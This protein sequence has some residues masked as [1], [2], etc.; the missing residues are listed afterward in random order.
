MEREYVWDRLILEALALAEQAGVSTELLVV[1]EPNPK[2]PADA[3]MELFSTAKMMDISPVSLASIIS[4]KVQSLPK[5]LI[6]AVTASGPYL[7]LEIDFEEFSWMVMKEVLRLG[8]DYGSALKSTGASVI[9]DYSSPNVAKRMH[10]GHI[11]STII[12]QALVNILR[13]LGH[14]TIGDNH[15]GDWGK[16]FGILLAGVSREG[17]PR[18]SSEGLLEQLELLYSRTS[19]LAREDP[20]VDEEARVWSLRLEQG[21]ELARDL[22]RRVV[23]LTLAANAASYERLGVEF[24]VIHGESFYEPMLADVVQDALDQGVARVGEGGA[25]VVDLGEEVPTFLLRRGDGGTLYH[26]RDLATIKYRVEE[27]A[28][29][30]IVYVIGEPQALYLRQLFA[31]S[32]RLGYSDNVKLVHVPFGTV[33]DL[34]GQ[35]LSTRKGNMVY[36]QSMLDSAKEHALAVI[37]GASRSMGGDE[38]DSVGEA[39]GIGAVIYNDLHQDPRRNLTLNWDQMLSIDGDSATYIQYMVA[40]CYSILRR[41]GALETRSQHSA[42]THPSERALIKMIAK[43]P[44]AVRSAG[45]EYKPSAIAHWCYAT[46]RAFAAFYRDCPVV[47]ETDATVR[48]PAST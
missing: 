25:V 15:I 35:P 33:F 7:N 20:G 12:G 48:P 39:V 21:E 27:Y 6:H 18:G 8:D 37:G 42:V 26:T 14:H 34:L 43:L 45:E 11:R 1:T 17:F 13:S 40:R 31:L 10:V 19:A 24:D 41:A 38:R 23:E 47:S 5:T 36:L 29:E 2:I 46:A 32:D 30:A 28:P 4:S 22:W 16:S 3:V 9:V 44:L